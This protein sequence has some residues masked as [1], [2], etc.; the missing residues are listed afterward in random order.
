MLLEWQGTAQWSVKEKG[1]LL[2][3]KTQEA[4]PFSQPPSWR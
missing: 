4:A 2:H 1:E 3:P